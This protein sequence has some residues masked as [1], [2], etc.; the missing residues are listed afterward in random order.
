ME[1]PHLPTHKEIKQHAWILRLNLKS[2]SF[3]TKTNAN[4]SMVRPSL[5]YC[6]SVWNPN[7]KEI[8]Q[9]IKM[10]QRRTARYVSSH[11]R[12]TSSVSSMLD[13]LQWESL[14]SRRTK[15]QLSLLFKI[16]NDLVDIRAD[17]YLASSTGSSDRYLHAQTCINLAFP[18]HHPSLKFPP[19]ISC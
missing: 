7:Q 1:K 2:T 5:E 14:E 18:L 16:I 13:A 10:I 17:D 4:I 6:A 9:K 8:I 15:I 12:N 19:S 11:F 3:E